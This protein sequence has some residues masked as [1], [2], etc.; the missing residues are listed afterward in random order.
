MPMVKRQPF[1]YLLIFI[2]TAMAWRPGTAETRG[3]ISEE[4]PPATCDPGS[5][6]TGV[7]CSGKYCDNIHISCK[8]FRDG[9]WG[10]TAY[11]MDWVSEEQGWRGVQ[12]PVNHFIAGLACRGRY[13]DDVSIY[14]VEGT[15]MAHLG[16]AFQNPISEET[17]PQHWGA[18]FGRGAVA[19]GMLCQGRYCDNMRFLVC[20][21]P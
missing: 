2:I 17:D 12:C 13:C 9:A 7:G 3:S 20:G 18:G 10:G 15:N 5:F 19:S 8:R 11:W 14:C 1:L 4:T 16:C 6:V 21:V